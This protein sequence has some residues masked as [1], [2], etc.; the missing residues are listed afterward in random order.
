[1][2][3]RFLLLAS[4]FLAAPVSAQ[5]M[6]DEYVGT[7]TSAG[8]SATSASIAGAGF[9]SGAN[10]SVQCDTAAYVRLVTSSTGTVSSANGILV[11]AGRLF[12]FRAGSQRNFLAVISVSGTS[13]CRVFRSW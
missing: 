7:V 1:M 5:Y 9:E 4:V 3:A 2:F 6:L 13:N 8:T 11:E 12:P 10:Y